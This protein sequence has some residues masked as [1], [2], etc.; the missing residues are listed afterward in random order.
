[1]DVEITL[2]NYRCFS[3]NQP[4]RFVLSK[5]F[6][7][8]VGPNNVGKSTLLKFLYEFRNLFGILSAG[9][10]NDDVHT[11]I[12]G[13]QRQFNLH[14]TTDAAGLFHDR[15]ERDIEVSIRFVNG[16]RGTVSPGVIRP[17]SFV[18]KIRRN[19][20]LFSQRLVYQNQ[21]LELEN[22]PFTGVDNG[23]LYFRDMSYA[24]DYTH[25]A[26]LANSLTQT[27]YVGPF[28]NI[29]NVGTNE[30]YFDIQVGQAFVKAWRVLKTGNNK[31]NSQATYRLQKDIER[32][33]GFDRLE[34]NPSDEDRTLQ[35]FV[36]GK[37]YLLSELGSGLAEFILVL[38]NA[39]VKKPSYILIDE[40]EIHLHPRLQRDFLMALGSY[41]TEGV[42]FATHNLGLARSSAER[43]FSVQQNPRGDRLVTRYEQTPKM[44]EFLGELSFSSYREMGFDKV[45]LVEGIHDVKTV[46]QFLRKYGKDHQIVLLPMG[47]YNL[48]DK[49]DE[50]VAELEE[51]KRISP[52]IVVLIDSERDA[53]EKPLESKRQKFVD[54]CKQI[55]VQCHVMKLRAIE[56]YLTTSAIQNVKGDKYSALQPYEKLSQV[57]FPWSK[58][59]NWRIAQEMTKAELD[60][61]DIGQ[62]FSSL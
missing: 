54:L 40:P 23:I 12:R 7:A 10:R 48:I 33:F 43:I 14:G 24:I 35:L 37:S 34:I 25:I 59:E 56:N 11:T 9:A 5:G 26:E 61:T 60:E 4:G 32:I 38:A 31:L 21:P 30:N 50:V 1:M 49:S 44:A 22:F 29:L 13:T 42:I 3:D 58:A 16:F 20:N 18:L 28:R 6:T 45:L 39:A 17:E 27:L 15:N 47:G 53:A 51:L 52:N 36:N 46:Q 55:D 62:F 8:F 2:K 41:A 19:E 57:A